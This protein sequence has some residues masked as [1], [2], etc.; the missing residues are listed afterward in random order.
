MSKEKSNID[1]IRRKEAE[2]HIKMYAENELFSGDGW[3][4]KPVKT[5]MDLFPLLDYVNEARILDLGCGVGRNSIPAAQYFSKCT[6]D[7]VDILDEAISKLFE[8]ATKFSVADKING[9]VSTVEDYS[10][11]PCYYDMIIAVSVLEHIDSERTFENKL[12]EIRNGLRPG[13]IVCI[14][15]NTDIT[16]NEKISGSSLAPQFELN[17]ETNSLLS[18]MHN[19]FDGLCILKETVS[20]QNYDVPRGEVVSVLK[21]RVV[22][23]AAKKEELDNNKKM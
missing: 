18:F 16:E 21:S 7:C 3:L 23:F 1:I 15:M 11:K 12:L 8:N 22:T 17:Y 9:I 20:E 19:V 2:S 4:N 10:I 14:I 6:V 5:V 13:G